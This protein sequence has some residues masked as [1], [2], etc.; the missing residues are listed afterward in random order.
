[1]TKAPT[2]PASSPL[3][4]VQ[5]E[6]ITVSLIPNNNKSE[7]LTPR[8]PTQNPSHVNLVIVGSPYSRL[9]ASAKRAVALHN[10]AAMPTSSGFGLQSPHHA[11]MISMIRR[12]SSA[13]DAFVAGKRDPQLAVGMAH[14]ISRWR[15]ESIGHCADSG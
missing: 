5:P 8:A 14:W 6:I 10:L 7:K 1:M 4:I 11:R 9:H 2:R 3:S 15:Q 13:G 12:G